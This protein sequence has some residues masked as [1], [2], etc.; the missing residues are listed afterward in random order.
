MLHAKKG[1]H[2]LSGTTSIG[3]SINVNLS[4]KYHN[5]STLGEGKFGVKKE[6]PFKKGAINERIEEKKNCRSVS[7]KNNT[8]LLSFTISLFLDI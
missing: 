4:I 2:N 6:A 8:I 7:L 1:A 5:Q 3:N